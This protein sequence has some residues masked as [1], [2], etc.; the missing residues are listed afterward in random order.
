MLRVIIIRFRPTLI[1]SDI[2]RLCL[3]RAVARAQPGRIIYR[4]AIGNVKCADLSHP[5]PSLP[6]DQKYSESPLSAAAWRIG[7][8]LVG[9]PRQ[10]S[11]PRIAYAERKLWWDD[12]LAGTVRVAM[13]H[14]VTPRR[15]A[16]GIAVALAEKESP[17]HLALEPIWRGASPDPFEQK[18]VLRLVEDARSHVRCGRYRRWIYRNTIRG[19][20]KKQHI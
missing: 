20:C 16:F 12:R 19:W 15:F 3:L 6:P 1:A 17:A 7:G 2:E 5:R 14:R 10:S 11:M 8:A 4:K 18:A 13:R 9:R